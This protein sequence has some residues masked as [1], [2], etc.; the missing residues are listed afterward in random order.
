[1]NE[2]GGKHL[3]DR[4]KKREG[5]WWSAEKKQQQANSVRK[6]WQGKLTDRA[7][8]DVRV[9]STACDC[10]QHIPA[11][12]QW[13]PLSASCL[14]LLFKERW[15]LGRKASCGEKGSFLVQPRNTLWFLTSPL[16]VLMAAVPLTSDV[17]TVPRRWQEFPPEGR[18]SVRLAPPLLLS[19][20]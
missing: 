7:L 18:C 16:Q 1:M 13:C 2:R 4:E 3:G 8:S 11:S 5:V 14:K 17:S 12:P 20:M 9:C 19:R 10:R 15:P 6:S